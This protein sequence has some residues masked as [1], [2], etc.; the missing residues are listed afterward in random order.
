MTAFKIDLT[1]A[2]TR[3]TLTYLSIIMALTLGFSAVLYQQSLSEA[4]GNLM[5]QQR[6][7]KDYLYFTR[8]GQIAKIADDQLELFKRNLVKRLVVLN[9]GMLVV[10][11]GVSYVFARRSLRPIEETMEA[12]SRFTSDAAHE[13]RTPLTAMKTEIEVALLAK[14]ISNKEAR[15]LL[16]SN[17]EE[18]D[19]LETLTA[20][21]LRLARSGDAVITTHWQD[22]KVQDILDSAVARL[23]DKAAARNIQIK[24]TKT[25]AQVHGDPDQ[26]V[27]LFVPLLGNAIKYSPDGSDITI[28]SKIKD[29]KV[30]T[31]ITDK[32]IGITEV[33][34]PHIF[35][36][37]YRADQ[38]RNKTKIDGYG[39][40]LS[41]A[42]AIAT[43]HKGKI[44]V[45]S[46]YGKGSTFTVELP[47]V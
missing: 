42:Q 32:G 26:L 8:P 46:T 17:L 37:F 39:L 30:F 45:T 2:R 24:M 23:K 3:L 13:L 7:L 27:E 14:T 18:I 29:N 31:S 44:N 15:E 22:Y 1:T 25:T 21:L 43:N 9:V 11:T 16:Q 47:T 6:D 20:A 5:R 19:K 33:D 28:S 41:L 35:E 40:G 12:Q 36:R 10:G 34:L 4:K 38:S